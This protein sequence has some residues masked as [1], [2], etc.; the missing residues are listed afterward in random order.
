MKSETKLMKCVISAKGK[1]KR[2][3]KPTPFRPRQCLIYMDTWLLGYLDLLPLVLRGSRMPERCILCRHGSAGKNVSLL[4]QN[5]AQCTSTSR[6]LT[7]QLFFFCF[8]LCCSQYVFVS[9]T[10]GIIGQDV[11]S[12]GVSALHACGFFLQGCYGCE[13]DMKYCLCKYWFGEQFW[14]LWIMVV[15]LIIPN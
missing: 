15:M 1:T 8:F 13:L 12:M 5:N 11:V 4:G 2:K 7:R 9:W 6:K 3:E 10:W 14:L